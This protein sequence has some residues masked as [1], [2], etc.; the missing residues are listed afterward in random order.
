MPSLFGALDEDLGMGSRDGHANV[1]VVCIMPDHVHLMLSMDGRGSA[2][3]EYVKVWKGLWT[4]RLGKDQRR[5]FWQRTFYDHWMRRDEGR[6]YAAYIVGNPVR[7]GL[8]KDWRDYP[9]T[10]VHVDW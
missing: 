3:W 1:V 9:Y 7:K 2:L 6:S 5:P 8:V 4:R 10:R